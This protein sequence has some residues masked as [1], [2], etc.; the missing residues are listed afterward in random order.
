MP[1]IQLISLAALCLHY[2]S[3]TILMHLSRT[4]QQNSNY[5]ASSA[6]VMTE[7]FKLFIS[8]IFA[9]YHSFCQSEP[10]T[11]RP[12]PHSRFEPQFDSLAE[13][14]EEMDQDDR[15]A[16]NEHENGTE[17]A[18]NENQSWKAEDPR[19]NEESD[20]LISDM[21]SQ[22]QS[23]SSK[24]RERTISSEVY[25][26]SQT[27]KRRR[28]ISGN[29]TTSPDKPVFQ[30]VSHVRPVSDP[31]HSHRMSVQ[32]SPQLTRLTQN[33]S[34]SHPLVRLFHAL[35]HLRASI[36]SPDWFL[37]AIP[38]VMFVIQN[39]LQYLAASNLS[40][41][42]FQI[43]YQLKIL[44]TALCSVI[45]LKRRLKKTQWVSLVLLTT[46]V[47]I[48]QLNSQQTS[49]KDL[50][51]DSKQEP[52]SEMN[53]LL[54]LVAVVSACLSSGFAS[55]YLERMLKSTGTKPN[56]NNNCNTELSKKRTT[57]H[58][59]SSPAGL[60]KP[61][62]PPSTSIWI[63][64]IQLSSFGLVV[65]L[66]IVFL[67]NQIKN[68]IQALSRLM[69]TLI[70][71]EGNHL[72]DTKREIFGRFT[73][74]KVLENIWTSKAEFFNGFSSLTWLVIFFQVTG[75][76]LN[77]AVMKYSNN[78][79]KNFSICLSIILSILFSNIIL[80]TD[81]QDSNHLNIQFFIGSS[82]VIFSTWLFNI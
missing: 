45:L 14:P 4:G 55:V 21:I 7:L 16:G 35:E 31:D 53:Q 29:G 2:S 49:N 60:H 18:E 65:S 40:V 12:S 59:S 23:N 41:P 32:A 47:A 50:I 54:G 48:V 37:L 34:P 11:S 24:T 80:S 58:S 26:P 42:L 71:F 27:G 74:Q 6:V 79:N 70:T 63:R 20:Q 3:L 1:S 81:D 82:F 13:E 51:S 10:P 44:T 15:R 57:L 43:T 64:N 36:F 25:Q 68:P 30:F 22:I 52:G 38:A 73:K 17:L 66:L 67:E 46:G 56:H 76:I 69:R 72:L 8:L 61:V 62:N 5:R 28:L 75:G 19:W 9:F 33:Y 78:I 77:S 39:N